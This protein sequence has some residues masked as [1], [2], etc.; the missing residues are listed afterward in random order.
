MKRKS[1]DQVKGPYNSNQDS[2]Y[3][4]LCFVIDNNIYRE[5]NGNS[6]EINKFAIN[7]VNIM[8]VVTIDY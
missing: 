8:N 6:R 4:E 5:H 7:V 3:V 2:Y 1:E